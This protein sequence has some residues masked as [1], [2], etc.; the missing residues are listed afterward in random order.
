MKILKENPGNLDCIYELSQLY[1][2]LRCFEKAIHYSDLLVRAC[3][4]EDYRL[5]EYLNWRGML[6]YRWYLLRKGQLKRESICK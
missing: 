3:E 1:N 2:R 5:D 4:E 6:K